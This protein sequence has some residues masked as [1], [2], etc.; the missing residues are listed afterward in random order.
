MRCEA[1]L[2]RPCWLPRLQFRLAILIRWLHR[3]RW[4]RDIFKD[5]MDQSGVPVRYFPGFEVA[6]I[7]TI[8]KAMSYRGGAFSEKP[9]RY[10]TQQ[11]VVDTAS[12][13]YPLAGADAWPEESDDAYTG[14]MTS[15]TVFFRLCQRAA[16]AAS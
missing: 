4:R 8:L 13:A 6:G 7:G 14:F 12:A 9:P 15:L 5:L 11:E 16:P 2:G 3:W 1:A 10:L